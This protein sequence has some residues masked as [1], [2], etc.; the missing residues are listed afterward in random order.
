LLV[1]A[2]LLGALSGRA[3][4]QSTGGISGTVTD[5]GTTAPLAGVIV[6]IYDESGSNWVFGMTDVSGVYTVTGLV[7]G[8]YYV[9]TSNVLG[10]IDELYDNLPCSSG[11]SCSVTTGTGVSVTA[12]A[13]ASGIDFGLAVGG[14][15]TGTVTDTGAAAPLAGVFVFVVDASGRTVGTTTTDPSGVYTV[16]GLATGTHYVRTSNSLGYIDEMYNDLPCPGSSCYPYTTGTGVS[17]TAGATTSGIDFGLA[18]GGTITGTVT[19]AGTTAPLADVFVYVFTASGSAVGYANTSASGVYTTTGLPSGTYYVHTWNS[20]GY[21]DELYIDVPCPTF[22]CTVTT[23]T[24]VSVTAGATTAGIDFGLGGFAA[25]DFNA[26]LKSDVLWRHATRGEVWLWPMDGA[27][28]LSETYVRTVPDTGWQ[29]RGLGDQTGDG[30]ADILWRHAPTGMIYFWP[31]SGGTPLSETYVSTVDPAY[32]IVGT[33]DY[34]GDGNSDILWRHVT[35]GAVWIWLM[36]GAT[37]LSQVYVDTVGPA[38]WVVGSGDVNGDRK[39]DIVWRHSTYG[40]VWVWLMN[41]TTRTSQTHVG[42][43]PDMGY[44]IV[45]VADYTGDGKADILWRHLTRGEVWIWPMDGTTVLSESYVDTVPDTGY[46]IVG[47]GD[48]NGN[49]KADI[50]W[51][52]ATRGEVWVWLMNGTT[53]VSETWVATVPEVGYQI[54][55]VK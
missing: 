44:E 52:H 19:D 55:K 38:Y 37:P 54:V 36:N 32:D 30:I 2:L 42:T 23:G 1:L 17:V 27:T 48:Y 49:G 46:R 39:A 4:A 18:V 45:G 51:H 53:K 50:L 34:D 10:Y 8:T 41:G 26:D 22:S 12:G 6:Y 3:E 35:T 21:I 15:I 11:G 13:T 20:L 16:P 14:T 9:R 47:T 7:A 28:R 5:A 24:G 31:M 40:E 25:G 33:G 43:V 29:I